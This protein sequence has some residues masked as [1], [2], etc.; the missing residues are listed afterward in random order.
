MPVQVRTAEPDDVESIVVLAI[1]LHEFTARGVPDRL[2]IPDE[3]D[4]TTLRTLVEGT[5][6]DPESAFLVA[7]DG[8]ETVGF[9]ELHAASDPDDPVVQ[10][11]RY[12]RLQSLIVTERRRGR[13]IG[14]L[15]VEA[16]KAWAAGRGIHDVRLSCW[17]FDG[18][19]EPFYRALGF[20][21]VRREMARTAGD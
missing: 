21:T 10:P 14:R 3:Y 20:R 19:P 4:L 13:G 18:G 8:G 7:V 15:L 11:C 16:S 17:E 5:I 2:R 12:V 9:A 1:E 6:A